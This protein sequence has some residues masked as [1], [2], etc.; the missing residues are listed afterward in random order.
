MTVIFKAGV[1]VGTRGRGHSPRRSYLNKGMNL[2]YSYP[3]AVLGHKEFRRRP[4]V[5]PKMAGMLG[6]EDANR[7]LA[8]KLNPWLLLSNYSICRHWK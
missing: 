2:P 4:P 5:T 3:S 1:E 6:I 8:F 7:T